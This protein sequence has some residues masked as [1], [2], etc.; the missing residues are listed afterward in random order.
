[1]IQMR[2]YQQDAIAAIKRDW[3]DGVDDTLFV[4]ATGGGKTQ[5]F[6]K[7]LMDEL[8][9]NPNARALCLAHRKELIEQPLDRIGQ[10]DQAWLMKDTDLRPRVGIVMAE[11]DD[12]DRQLTIATI[13]TL[14]S[15]TRLKRLLTNGPITHLVTD[16]CHRAVAATY[17]KVYKA[18]REACPTMKHLGVTATPIRGDGAGLVAV[19]QKDSARVTI[20]DLVRLGWLVQ[21]RWLGISTGISIAGVKSA[22][23]DFVQSQLA[24]VF[25]TDRGRDVIV[26][27]YQ[28]YAVD[29]PA[30]AF[31]TSVAGAH[32]LA[33]AFNAVGIPAAAI[34]GTT[35][36]EQ[37]SQILRDFKADKYRVLANC[38]VL[39]EGWD[40]PSVS[41]V[42][43]CRP[44]RSDLAYTQ[45]MGRGL[46]P[47]MGQAQPGEDCL[48]LDFLPVE[49]RN[50][51]MA[52]DVLGLPRSVTQVTLKKNDDAEPGEVQAGFTFDG[53]HFNSNGSA[54]EI[55]AR[56]L[57]YL[58]N[59]P[60]GW[61][62]RDGW[63]IL[64]LG[65][66]E[67]HVSRTLA[68][69]PRDGDGPCKL[70]GLKS[71]KGVRSEI[72]H[73]AEG[74]FGDVSEMARRYAERWG[75]GTLT[76]KERGWMR[77]PVSEGQVTTLQKFG[78]KHDTL[79]KMSR[80][81]ASRLIT[82]S[83]SRK[84]LRSAGYL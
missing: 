31:T 14:A 78:F 33:E 47:A 52:G 68:I 38:Q 28:Q 19:Y 45:M 51:I 75:D 1:M 66:D 27:S 5:V 12:C 21:P 54:L 50:I 79:A 76:Q 35:P 7:L 8:D 15:E 61:D 65:T 62:P 53:E 72:L 40:C 37:R 26:R 63:L 64:S 59:T 20:A 73:L 9:T 3:S 48:I 22:G 2:E 39:T 17:V 32:A 30:V 11:R 84:I 81:E 74:P 36:K 25:D 6:L 13:Q 77:Q 44:T 60:F 23:G 46:R 49:T 24:T 58:Q 41:C 16:E 69:T 29:R 82:W 83:F 70:L 43:M 80:G 4:M 18:L 42:L 55:I 67:N 56:E 10:I 71:G 34:D 57:D